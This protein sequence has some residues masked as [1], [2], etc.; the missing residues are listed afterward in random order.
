MACYCEWSLARG[1][2]WRQERFTLDQPSERF[3]RRYRTREDVAPP[4]SNDNV[5]EML[6]FRRVQ[7]ENLIAHPTRS[8][9]HLE[10]TRAGLAE[11][12]PRGA[13]ANRM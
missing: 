3:V 6:M 2:T 5:V 7:Y 10:S 11:S 4:R 12:R 1:K 8:R 9:G 13:L